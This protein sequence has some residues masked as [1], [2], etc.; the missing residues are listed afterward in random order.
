MMATSA[1]GK[2]TLSVR[3]QPNRAET[4][5][6]FI[7]FAGAVGFSLAFALSGIT[8]LSPSEEAK[9]IHDALS[10]QFGAV[11]YVRMLVYAVLFLFGLLWGYNGLHELNL[12]QEWLKPEHF[13]IRRRVLVHATSILVGVLLGVLFAVTPEFRTLIYVFIFYTSVDLLLWKLRRDEI[14]SL[15][16][17]SVQALERD[18]GESEGYSNPIRLQRVL[19]IFRQGAA[20]LKEYYLVRSHYGR[21]GLQLI[22]V[23]ALAAI[24]FSWEQTFPSGIPVDFTPD[25]ITIVG[26]LLFVWCLSISEVTVYIWRRDLDSRLAALARHLHEVRAA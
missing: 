1:L 11:T 24:Q 15:I 14:A 10:G 21:V 7:Q 3:T 26:Y 8:R 25:G 23:V 16:E 12:L 17:G 6:Q 18:F 2:W 19:N 4:F 13:V 20:L 5:R 22:G 9:L